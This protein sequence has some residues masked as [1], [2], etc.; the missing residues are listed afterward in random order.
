MTAAT[1]TIKRKT[2]WSA[3]AVGAALEATMEMIRELVDGCDPVAADHL[4]D[5][6]ELQNPFGFFQIIHLS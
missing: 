5:N 2:R 1:V 3:L 6:F 4:L